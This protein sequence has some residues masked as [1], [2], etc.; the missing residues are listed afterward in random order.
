[1]VRLLCI[2]V[3]GDLAMA[4]VE[5]DSAQTWLQARERLS[6]PYDAVVCG[7]WCP[8]GHSAFPDLD[9][10][11][12]LTYAR[13]V[14]SAPMYVVL[15]QH[16][17]EFAN[18]LQ[19]LAE[20]VFVVGSW[21]EAWQPVRRHLARELSAESQIEPWNELLLA[22]SE[23]VLYAYQ[24]AQAELRADL[25]SF[26]HLKATGLQKVLALGGVQSCQL[27]GPELQ[28]QARFLGENRSLWTAHHPAGLAYPE[29]AGEA[30]QQAL[31]TLGVSL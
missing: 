16:Q 27:Q 25:L 3:E 31:R 13:A 21:K 23:T 15:S 2:A 1:M 4:G 28:C 12:I 8:S 18:P 29:L 22:E 10:P 30:Q 20:A 17:A 14:G 7:L 9:A 26:L 24:C 19:G 6:Q 11:Q 5:I